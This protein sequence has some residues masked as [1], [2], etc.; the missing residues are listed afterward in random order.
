MKRTRSL[1]QSIAGWAF[2]LIAVG[3]AG[4]VSSYTERQD[5]AGAEELLARGDRAFEGG[6]FA[7]SVELYKLAAA[8]ASSKRNLGAF[9]EAAAQ[10]SSSLSLLGRPEDGES[11]LNQARDADDG[12]GK[13]AHARVLLAEAL[14]L[15]DTDRIAAS[16][17]AF[18]KLYG[19]CMETGLWGEAMQAATL[20]SVVAEGDARLEWARRNLDAA[21]NSGEDGW[22]AA[23]WRGLGFAQEAAGDFESAVHSIREGRKETKSGTRARLRDDWALAHMLRMTRK[24]PE[25]TKI[26]KSAIPV[27]R[28]FHSKG[29]AP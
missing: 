4:C 2:V 1:S 19:A 8:A 10:V 7:E 9:V 23:G 14:N 29:F 13:R 5:S 24:L 18:D 21:R 22:I 20:A 17:H 26:L 16:L 25:A 28:R 11:W 27:A 3:L 12:A 6:R 15:R